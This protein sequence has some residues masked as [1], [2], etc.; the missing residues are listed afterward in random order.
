MSARARLF[1]VPAV[2]ATAALVLWTSIGTFSSAS[3]QSP[4]PTAP[5]LIARA[6]RGA[7]R[8]GFDRPIFVLAIGTDARIGNPPRA[9]FDSIHIAAIDPATKRG[10]I[11]GI[12]RDF[13]VNIPGIG[14]RK[15]N[16]AGPLGGPELLMR[17]IGQNWGC[18]FDYYMLT[19][20]QG[21]AGDWRHDPRNE[22]GLINQVG[23]VPFDVPKT[24]RS[25]LPRLVPPA[26]RHRLNGAQSL[27][28]S[29]N[30]KEWGRGDIDR[31]LNQGKLMVATLGE[32]RRDFAENPGTA[33]RNLAALRRN[34]A[35]DVPVTEAIAL[36]LLALRVKP[37]NVRN[38]V[39][40]GAIG[41]AGDASVVRP[42]ARGNDQLFD[43]C[44]D[45]LLDTT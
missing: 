39:A 3:G 1:L 34:I 12:P 29:R 4:T 21:F 45:G 19:G 42:T 8:P 6:T 37:E 16:S 5:V 20:F 33:L 27:S 2:A 28:W 22:Q 18:R 38:I 11:V 14:T 31:S 44:N 23:G 40:D 13:Y 35:M 41:S 7:Y 36:G 25:K 17:T 43:V 26:G 32:M 9:L 15:I 24:L 30:R 10:S